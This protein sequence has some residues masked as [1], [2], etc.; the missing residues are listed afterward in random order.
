MADRLSLPNNVRNER[1]KR[2]NAGVHLRDLC[3]D[4]H[5]FFRNSGTSKLQ[6]AQFA[7]DHLPEIAAGGHAPRSS[8]VPAV[9]RSFR[10]WMK[11]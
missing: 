3:A 10:V 2:A 5:A 7:P 11:R 8:A 1:L 6:S 4:M 9:R